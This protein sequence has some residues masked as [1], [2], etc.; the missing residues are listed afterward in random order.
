MLLLSLTPEARQGYTEYCKAR[1]IE[2]IDC[3]YPLTPEMQV[4]GDNHPN[5]TM[6][7]LWANCIAEAAHDSFDGVAGQIGR[8]HV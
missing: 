7:T 8:A 1:H 6:H 2:Y 4:P 5:G 3:A